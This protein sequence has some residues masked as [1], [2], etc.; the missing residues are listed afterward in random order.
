MILMR[1]NPVQGP[2]T[3]WAQKATRATRFSRCISGPKSL[4]FQGPPLPMALVMNF[5]AFKAV[6]KGVLFMCI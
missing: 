6:A 2:A 1:A 4:D 3:F 5:Q